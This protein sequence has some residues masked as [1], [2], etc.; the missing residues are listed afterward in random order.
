MKSNMKI[1]FTLDEETADKL[2]GMM[3]PEGF[4]RQLLADALGEFCSQR[5]PLKDYVLG[6][7]R[8]QSFLFMAKKAQDVQERIDIARGVMTAYFRLIGFE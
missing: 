6:R 7:Y 8:D 5:L 2:S 4:L 1:E 3:D